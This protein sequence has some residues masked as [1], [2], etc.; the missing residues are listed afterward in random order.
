MFAIFLSTLLILHH[1]MSKVSYITGI[2]RFIE[3][4][5]DKFI[6]K[7]KDIAPFGIFASNV[8][9]RNMTQDASHTLANSILAMMKNDA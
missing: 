1:C 3:T 5:R 4:V 2:L 9:F 8:I 6:D 7:Q